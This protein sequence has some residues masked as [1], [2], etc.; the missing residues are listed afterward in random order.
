MKTTVKFFAITGCFVLCFILFNRL[1]PEQH[2]IGA[3][4]RKRHLDETLDL[5][6]SRRLAQDLLSLIYYRYELNTV[7]GSTFFLTS[8]NI[9][10]WV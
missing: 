9:G 1:N 2:S 3:D 5:S 7:V 8:N 10:K 6:R 4:L